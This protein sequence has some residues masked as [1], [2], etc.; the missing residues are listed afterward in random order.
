MRLIVVLV[1]ISTA[2]LVTLPSSNG[3]RLRKNKQEN[4]AVDLVSFGY[5]LEYIQKFLKDAVNLLPLEQIGHVAGCILI[6]ADDNYNSL[7][8][9]SI[10]TADK[11][12]DQLFHCS[13]KYPNRK[14]LGHEVGTRM[15][16]GKFLGGILSDQKLFERIFFH[17]LGFKSV[18]KRGPE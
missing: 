6:V 4:S 14:S 10:W 15:E 17:L 11:L 12:I 5:P 18:D 3:H 2:I 9:F 8:Q 1:I 7:D 16:T 13:Q